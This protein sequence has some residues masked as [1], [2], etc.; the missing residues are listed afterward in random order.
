MNDILK[1]LCLAAAVCI[2]M[3]CYGQQYW[4]QEADLKIDVR[5]NDS[6]NF[7]D[8]YETINYTN[9][10]PDTLRYIF[11]HLWPNAY[12]H[13]H[14]PFAKQ[15]DLNHSTA[16][17]YSRQEDRGYIDSL[18]FQVNGQ[19]LD[20]YNTDDVP[21]IARIDLS[22]PL[23]PGGKLVISTPFRVKIPKVFS[24]MGH[25]GQAYFISQWFPKPA[26]YDRKG[27]HPISY[28]DQGEFY[29]EYG[30][31]DV[32]IT[33]P[34]NYVVMAT[35]NCT[36][37]SENDWLDS[38]AAAPLPSDTAYEDGWPK[39]DAKLKTIHYHED[40][41]HDFAWFADKRWIVRKDGVASPGNGQYVTTW[42]AFLPTHKKQWLKGND[43]LKE[44]INSYGSN[45]GAYPYKTIKAVE[46]D[47]HAGGGMEYPTVTIID[48]TV[49]K[50]LH[51]TIVH[52][53]GH[54]WF[55]GMLGTME[56]DHAWMDEGINTFYE[57]K[58]TKASK[59]DTTKKSERTIDKFTSA[60][61]FQHMVSQQDQAIEQTS[62]NFTTINYGLDVYFKTAMMMRWLEQYMG[63]NDFK[64][65]MQ[66][67]YNTWKFKHPYPEDL[68]AVLQKHTKKNIDWFFTD[69]LTTDK[70][71]DL[72]INKVKEH[73]GITDLTVRSKNNLLAPA[74]ID[75]YKGDSLLTKMVS[76]PFR[77]E[78]KMSIS[79][80]YSGWTKLKLDNVIPDAKT[81][82][83]ANG[84]GFGIR[85]FAG[86]NRSESENVFVSPIV[87]Y[88][89]YDGVMAGLVLHNLTIPE[90]R[91]RFVIMP[92]YAFGSKSLVGA[93]SV[94]YMWYPDNIFKELLLQVDGK[95]YHYYGDNNDP[96]YKYK[97]IAPS[98][99]F[100]FNEHDLLS[101]VKRT[102]TLKAYYIIEDSLAYGLNVDPASRSYQHNYGLLRYTHQNSRTYNPFSYSA[103]GQV[104]PDFAKINLVGTAQIDYNRPGKALYIRAYL[105]KFFAINSDPTVTNRYNLATSYTGANDYLYDGTYLGRNEINGLAAE[106]ISMQEGGF[107]VPVHNS[108]VGVSDNWLGTINLSSDLPLPRFPVRLF[109][110]AGLMPNPHPDVNN[111]NET[112]FMYDGGFEIYL[113]KNVAALYVPLFMSSDFSNYLNTTYGSKNAFKRSVSFYLRLQNLNWLKAPS[114]VMRSVS[115]G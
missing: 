86:L 61:L 107:K 104:S 18:S 26:V 90:N 99:N 105:G 60:A 13:D 92:T 33:L 95:T 34:R 1:H 77:N 46:G 7:L 79:S 91:F 27:W 55:Y 44:T 24:R 31:F 59:L 12:K 100:T 4:Q 11:I 40:K 111:P 9:N 21:D 71:I 93:G 89:V 36:D 39:S 82:N 64:Y 108:T 42:T 62:A 94:G 41:V 68:Q 28:L 83:N 32:S 52:E 70:K 37:K 58:T 102:L 6:S 8:A 53:G 57:Q 84:R 98:L 25:T 5:L 110:D 109:L 30:T 113:I 74:I 112:K 87:G 66:D 29:S 76:E 47:M 65:G 78:T 106:Q 96:F 63:E 67:Y 35:G 50:Q 38:L 15:E 43:Y 19:K 10:S 85:L 49:Y 3:P 54:N 22:S 17:Y 56:R 97:K 81:A 51:A 114:T 80:E 69:G 75:V 20:Y 103:E 14:T 88:N 23:L 48:R 16:F 73:E 2:G 72:S 101:P 45:V 115:G